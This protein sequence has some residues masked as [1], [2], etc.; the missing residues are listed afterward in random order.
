[1]PGFW[2]GW[3]VL[4]VML[5]LEGST[6]SSSLGGT[7]VTACGWRRCICRCIRP[8]TSMGVGGRVL[9]VA[10]VVSRPKGFG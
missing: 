7:C 9:R 2:E 8:G 1:M 10:R 6:T 3:L 4:Q 5:V